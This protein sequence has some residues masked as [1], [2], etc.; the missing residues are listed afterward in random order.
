MSVR[1]EDRAGIAISMGLH[2]VVLVVLSLLT[3]AASDE[4]Q[5]GF[6]EV[7]F[8]PLSEGRPVQQAPMREQ[9]EP[10]PEIEQEEEEQSPVAPPD[11]VKPVELPDSPLDAPD[12]EIVD[13]PE[14]E[15]I[16]PE[17]SNTEEEQVDEEA[18]PERDVVLPLGSGS[19]DPD[20][21]E[22]SGDDGSS[23]QEQA[24]APFRIEGLNREPVNTPLPV[25]LSQNSDVRVTVRITVDPLGNVTQALP[26]RRGDPSQD[27][28]VLRV[29]RGW[30]FNPL[31]ST[32]PQE[33]QQGLITFVFTRR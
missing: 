26:V 12:E 17:T 9:P 1:K 30:R 25:F 5:M 23:N 7:E 14:S 27:R 32:A 3:A 16:A 11:E 33:P 13:A 24:S 28:E 31:P 29:V 21:G 6:L 2:V 22:E 4:Q 20:Q 10:E 18:E 19:L 15:V 8:G